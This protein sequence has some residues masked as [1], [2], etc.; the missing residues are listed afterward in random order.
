MRTC[1]WHHDKKMIFH[2][3]STLFDFLLVKVK[4]FF[5][6]YTFYCKLLS[7]FVSER[8]LFFQQLLPKK[9]QIGNPKVK[10]GPITEIHDIETPVK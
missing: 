9:V 3:N 7:M 6:I 10:K 2:D 5:D 4:N 1:T 8:F